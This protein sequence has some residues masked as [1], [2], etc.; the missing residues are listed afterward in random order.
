MTIDER[1]EMP[2]Y[3]LVEAVHNKWLKQYENNMT[4]TYGRF[5]PCIH[6]DCKLHIVVE[7][8]FN[9]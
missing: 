2:T 7:R 1:V 9:W 8:W 4:C 6:V 5:D 3:N